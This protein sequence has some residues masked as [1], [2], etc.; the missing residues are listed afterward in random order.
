MDSLQI[1]VDLGRNA[2]M[3]TL[4]L[5]A[6]LLLVGLVIGLGI[7]ILQA[8]TSIQEQTL[9]FVPKILGV[10]IVTALILPWMATRL[11]E[12]TTDLF[13]RLPVIFQ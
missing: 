10:I 9:T 2:L 13:I 11:I 6:P 7:S 12:Y 8:A 3:L 4:A 5:S 1:A